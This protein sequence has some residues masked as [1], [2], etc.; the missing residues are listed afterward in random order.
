MN[1]TTEVGTY[2]RIAAAATST[3][4]T[5]PCALLGVRVA[6]IATTAPFV[7]VWDGSDAT[8]AAGTIVIGTSTLA[9]NTYHPMP[10]TMISGLT[11]QATAE[12][13]VDLTFFYVPMGNNT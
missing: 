8:L 10:A 1:L 12:V 13:E 4:V 9:I 2:K 11:I 7:Q 3:I 5:G 6:G